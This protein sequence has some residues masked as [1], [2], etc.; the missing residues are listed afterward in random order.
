[1]NGGPK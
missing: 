1:L